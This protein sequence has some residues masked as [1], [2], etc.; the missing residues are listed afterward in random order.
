MLLKEIGDAA[1][2]GSLDLSGNRLRSLPAD[3]GKLVNLTALVLKDNESSRHLASSASYHSWR[4][5]ISA[6]TL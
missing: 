2:L 3:M 6:A 4:I 1:A 5:L